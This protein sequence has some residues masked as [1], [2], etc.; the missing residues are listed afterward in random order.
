MKM[1][2]KAVAVLLALM[3]ILGCLSAM[4]ETTEAAE[5]AEVGDT[6]VKRRIGGQGEVNDAVPFT[7]GRIPRPCKVE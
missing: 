6:T 7:A 4:A 5:T 1:C 2:K 3:M